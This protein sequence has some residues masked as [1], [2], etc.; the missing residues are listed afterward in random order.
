[1][2]CGSSSG[3]KKVSVV[4]VVVVFEMVAV[5]IVVSCR[6]CAVPCRPIAV[7]VQVGSTRMKVSDDT[8]DRNNLSSG[9]FRSGSCSYG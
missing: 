5:V 2:Y 1:M 7:D 9:T 3:K 4:L 6:R 8:D